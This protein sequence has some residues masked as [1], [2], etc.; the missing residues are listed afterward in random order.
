MRVDGQIRGD[1]DKGSE[2]ME[3]APGLYLVATPIGNLGDLAPRAVATLAGCD[4]ILAE[5]TRHTGRLLAHLGIDRPLA[6]LDDHTEAQAAVRLAAEIAAGGRLALVSDAGTPLINDPGFLLVRACRAAGV[7]V[8]GVPGPSAPLFALTLSGL[9]ADR[10]TFTGFVPRK[11]EA[12]RGWL[13]ELT[14]ATHTWLCLESPHR[15]VATLEAV[16]AVVDDRRVAVA[17]ELTKLHEEVRVARAA[18]LAS[19]Y[20]THPPKGEICLVIEGGDRAAVPGVDAPLLALAR[21]LIAPTPLPPRAAAKLVA[22]A[23]GA[24]ANDLYRVLV[25]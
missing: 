11:G 22:A 5:D 1:G 12:R 17:R 20:R 7:A 16:A 9:P 23:T 3:L 2:P 10:F 15:L 4:R 14:R 13:D 19:H 18:E 24:A 21:A 8:C 25:R 6:R